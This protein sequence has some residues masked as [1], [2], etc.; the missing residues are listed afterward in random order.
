MTTPRKYRWLTE[1]Q[2]YVYSAALGKGRD[3]LRGQACRIITVPRAG[4]K[5]A[6]VLVEFGGGERHIVP[7]GVLRGNRAARPF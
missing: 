5:P 7:S 4:S 3:D 6:N 2:T 1:G